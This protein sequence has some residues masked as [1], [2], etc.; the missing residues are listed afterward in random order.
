MLLIT[1]SI[2]ISTKCVSKLKKCEPSALT[3]SFYYV[4]LVYVHVGDPCGLCHSGLGHALSSYSHGYGFCACVYGF[5]WAHVYSLHGYDSWVLLRRSRL[6]G[7]SGS[8]SSFSRWCAV[9]S[10][11]APWVYSLW[12]VP[13]GYWSRCAHPGTWSRRS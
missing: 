11:S 2:K 3:F 8:N 5:L 10:W 1:W 12:P 6:L 13:R 7:V 4:H 9:W